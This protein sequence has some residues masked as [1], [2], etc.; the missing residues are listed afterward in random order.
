MAKIVGLNF[1]DMSSAIYYTFGTFFELK[2]RETTKYI[3]ILYAF[4]KLTWAL[5]ALSLLSI[6]IAVI[7]TKERKINDMVI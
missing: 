5:L 2:P 3:N 7:W 6:I 1:G 4:D